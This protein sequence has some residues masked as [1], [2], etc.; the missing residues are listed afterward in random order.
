MAI[1]VLHYSFK[2]RGSVQRSINFAMVQS[3]WSIG[4]LIVED[5]QKG[6]KRAEYG[7]AVLKELSEQLTKEFGKGFD[8][9]NLRNMRM[10]YLVFP[11]CDALRHELSWTHYRYLLRV[12]SNKAREWYMNEAV[13]EGWSSRQLD[14]QISVLYYDRILASKN[15]SEVKEEAVEK[16]KREEAEEFIKD[17]YVLEFLGLPENP[18]LRESKLEQL[19]ISNLQDLLLELG[20]GFCYVARQ[21]RIQFDEDNFYIDL[22]FYNYILK[23]HVLIDLKIGKLTHQDVGQMDS[24]VR[25]YDE[26]YRLDGDNPTIGIILCSEKNDAI[27]KYSILNDAKQIFASKYKFTLPTPEELQEKL[28]K[29]RLRIE[30]NFNID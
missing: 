9:S 10:F 14:R 13:S 4:K 3:Y 2:A 1:I 26:K 19:L 6:E 7:K 24:Y 23:C 5:E 28:V 11:N 8:A 30:N 29:E 25:M 15:N 21:K 20:R 16:L 22:V 12:E 18:S 27:V 17:P